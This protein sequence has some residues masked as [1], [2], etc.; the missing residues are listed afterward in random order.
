MKPTHCLTTFAVSQSLLAMSHRGKAVAVAVAAV[1][2]SAA[3]AYRVW[4]RRSSAGSEGAPS[5]RR[6]LSLPGLVRSVAES[7]GL[8]V[9]GVVARL[10]EHSLGA[11]DAVRA[12]IYEK[13]RCDHCMSKG[14][15]A[16]RSDVEVSLDAAQW[17]HVEEVAR[18][19][20]IKSHSKVVRVLLNYFAE[21]TSRVHGLRA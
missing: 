11:D 10:V 7:S 17:R 19:H 20:S 12:E 21:D 18:A 3:L 8:S 2:A 6:T 1:A 13:I 4:T 9:S 16:P 5:T 15:T 14:G